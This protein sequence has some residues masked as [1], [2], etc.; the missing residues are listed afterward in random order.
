MSENYEQYEG[1]EVQVEKLNYDNNFKEV[2]PT[3]KKGE[4]MGCNYDIGITVVNKKNKKDYM[5]CLNGPSSPNFKNH[6]I[7][8]T[9]YK[10][11]FELHIEQIKSGE[12]NYKKIYDLWDL[13]HNNRPGPMAKCAFSL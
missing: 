13:F 12:L 8:E 2:D 5:I 9:Q 3:I 4:V 7:T 11:M 10:K 6:G 1:N